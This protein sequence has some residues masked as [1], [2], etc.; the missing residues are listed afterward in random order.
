MTPLESICSAATAVTTILVKIVVCKFIFHV[1]SEHRVFNSHFVEGRYDDPQ[2]NSLSLK[3]RI[4][5][6]ITLYLVMHSSSEIKKK[7]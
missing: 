4:S 6:C 2:I 7:K 3:L 1:L 5:S